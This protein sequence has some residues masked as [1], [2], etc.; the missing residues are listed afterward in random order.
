MDTD[1]SG[2]VGLG[3]TDQLSPQEQSLRRYAR[4]RKDLAQS[5]DKPLWVRCAACAHRC[6]IG[7]NRSGVCKVRF[8]QAGELFVPWGYSAWGL[9]LDPIEKKPFFHA[10]PGAT[11]LSFGMVGCNFHCPFC[12]NWESSQVLRN[13]RSGARLI[14]VSPAEM[15]DSARHNGARA[16][17]STYNEPLITAEWA[18][19]VFDEARRAG[20]ATAMVSNGHA[21]PEVL[22]FLKPRLDLLKIDL[23][24]AQEKEYRK[25]G[26][27]LQHVL[28]GI[29]GAIAR[30]LWVE[31]VT[32]VIPGFNDSDAELRE[33]AA[34]LAGQSPDLPWH[35]TA[36]HPDYMFQ[37]RPPTPVSRLLRAVEIGKEEGLRFVYPGNVGGV[38]ELEST[39]CPGCAAILIPRRGFRISTPKIQ[40]GRCP[41]CQTPIPGFWSDGAVPLA[42][43]KTV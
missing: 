30:G 37:D 18:A 23:K 40:N 17:V 41:T 42:P 29:R 19:D 34:F 14:P 33:I 35:V 3:D 15:V 43:P 16:V 20:L 39:R 2:E 1:Q 26:G 24:T 22:D 32:L 38:Q 6:P 36:F 28:D 12:Q 9:A 31:V 5:G 21:T 4:A 27:V 10:L 25:L 7:P 11:T 8:N 13:P